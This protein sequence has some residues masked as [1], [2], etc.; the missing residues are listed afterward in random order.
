MKKMLFGMLVLAVLLAGCSDKK[1]EAEKQL[2]AL[3]HAQFKEQVA[4]IKI[5]VRNDIPVAD[6]SEL[7][8][9][10]E[11]FHEVNQAALRA[12]ET[13]YNSLD[14]SLKVLSYLKRR[15]LLDPARN[16]TEMTLMLMLKPD[17]KDRILKG[18]SAS[19]WE[20]DAAFWSVIYWPAATDVVV[21]LCD[22]I[23]EK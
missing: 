1:A 6:L 10:L 11:I 9:Q 8:N 12:D 16:Q 2:L 15:K 23:L 18:M 7:I 20:Q 22:G 14:A 19:N 13:N 21:R 17:L 4:N 3:T 5:R